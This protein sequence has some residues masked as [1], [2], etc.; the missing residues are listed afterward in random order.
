M[1]P[2][3]DSHLPRLLG[4]VSAGEVLPLREFGRR[5]GLASRALADAQRQG[6]RTVLFGRCKFVIGSDVV[7]WFQS[8]AE[9]QAGDGRRFDLQ[10]PEATTGQRIG[11]GMPVSAE[12]TAVSRQPVTADGTAGARSAPSDGTQGGRL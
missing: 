4:S 3:P 9:Q 6:L 12:Q 10:E 1:R 11:V 2:R 7:A 5:L 8:L